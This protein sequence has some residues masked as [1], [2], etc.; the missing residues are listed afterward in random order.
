MLG[1]LVR[2]VLRF[3]LLVALLTPAAEGKSSRFRVPALRFHQLP[4]LTALDRITDDELHRME[5]PLNPVQRL[6]FRFNLQRAKGAA[7]DDPHEQ[8]SFHSMFLPLQIRREMVLHP[9]SRM[10]LIHEA[11][12]LLYALQL[13]DMIP[14]MTGLRENE[15]AAFQSEYRFAKRLL[16][17]IDRRRLNRDLLHEDVTLARA[18]RMSERAYVR[19]RIHEYG[20]DWISRF[21]ARR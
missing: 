18:R 3:A 21:Y 6:L 16:R 5:R 19:L 11:S 15:A 20:M 14:S 9:E 7:I 12:H 4:Q 1:S 2:T 10:V 8:G 13:R 17:A